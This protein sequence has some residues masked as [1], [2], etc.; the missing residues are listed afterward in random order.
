MSDAEPASIEVALSVASADQAVF[1]DV[2]LDRV[3][4]G[5]HHA[6]ERRRAEPHV[7]EARETPALRKPRGQ[8]LTHPPDLAA[9]GQHDLGELTL[10][11]YPESAMAQRTRSEPARAPPASA[12]DRTDPA[13]SSHASISSRPT[14]EGAP[15]DLA[16]ATRQR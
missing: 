16:R 2:E 14:S 13:R 1:V 3:V 15:A 12:A 7:L 4:G 8:S 10:G 11:G 9:L 5:R 6:G